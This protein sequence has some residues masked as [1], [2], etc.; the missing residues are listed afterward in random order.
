MACEKTG[1]D[2]GNNDGNP[3]TIDETVVIGEYSGT[4]GH[5]LRKI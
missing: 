2:N 1:N 3:S 5:F 4:M